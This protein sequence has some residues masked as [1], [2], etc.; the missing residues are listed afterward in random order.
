MWF[1]EEVLHAE[2]VELLFGTLDGLVVF[3]GFLGV[4]R[5]TVYMTMR[6]W[7]YFILLPSI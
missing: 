7:A 5:G 1:L 3:D 2:M 6:C 4:M